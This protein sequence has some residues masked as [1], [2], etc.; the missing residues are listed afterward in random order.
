MNEQKPM[1]LRVNLWFDA[2]DPQAKNRAC[3]LWKPVAF[4]PPIGMDIVPFDDG[5]ELEWEWEHDDVKVTSYTF[6]AERSLVVATCR[7][8][9]PEFFEPNDAFWRGMIRAGW[10]RE[11][12]HSSQWD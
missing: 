7:L 5:E 10:K 1:N 11:A 3:S 2:D 4:L 8:T 6:F 9:R 12:S